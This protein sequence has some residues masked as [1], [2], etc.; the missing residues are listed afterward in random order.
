MSANAGS[1]GWGV[2]ASNTSEARLL[3]RHPGVGSLMT[4][5]KRRIPGF[6]FDYLEGGVGDELCISRNRRA[7]DA[8]EIVP[9][10]GDDVSQI[11]TA[12]RLFGQDYDL[13]LGVAPMGLSG[14]V[15]PDADLF[16]A[17]AAEEANIP[18]IL[19]MVSNVDV[20]TVCK[21]APNTTWQQL[22]AVPQSDYRVVFDMVDRAE[23]AGVRALV[24]TMDTPMRQKR[25]RDTRN[26]L[27]VP[28]RATMRTVYQVATSPRWALQVLRSG[29][30]RFA[31]FVPYVEGEATPN[32][33]AN[34]VNEHM[35]GPTTWDLIERVRARWKKPLV[36]KGHQH[37]ED[38]VRAIGLGVDGLIV[39]NHGGRQF[40]AAP[41]AIDVLQD[42]RDRLGHGVP[43]MID[44]SICSGLDVLKSRICGA[45]F[46]FAGRPFLA[47]TAA[48]GKHGPAHMAAMYRAELRG[49]MGQSGLSDIS[50]VE[51]AMFRMHRAQPFGNR[52]A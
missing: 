19:S 30:P 18:F 43:I 14:L 2:G 32:K 47:A 31:N 51:S 40:D 20:E 12:V 11:Q 7:L 13:P 45:D 22:Y 44:G 46:V 42:L 10:Y 49:A 36:L 9:R 6:A 28:F 23:R 26:G 5:A 24:L 35:V 33:V 16:I 38:A 4:A 41:A 3:R 17:K 39:S 50:N 34:Y 29:Q 25:L 37:A 1:A 27:T 21:F 15:W 48:L 8:I 52:H